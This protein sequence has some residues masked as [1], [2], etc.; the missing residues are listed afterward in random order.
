M[1]LQVSKMS[2][3]SPTDTA[4]AGKSL[5][6]I[7][8]VVSVHKAID[9][10]LET[11]DDWYRYTIAS[12]KSRITGLHRGTHAEVKEYAE[13]CADSFNSRSMATNAKSLTWSSRSK[14]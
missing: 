6:P 5:Q 12:G 13:G 10:G 7:Y 3:Q 8:R 14:K 2:T 4:T 1:D 9:P 11:A